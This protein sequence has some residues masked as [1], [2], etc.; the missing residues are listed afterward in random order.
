[1]PSAQFIAVV[2]GLRV[3]S[4]GTEIIKVGRRA[5]GVKLVIAGR[6]TGAGFGTAP[7]LVVADEI[8]LAAVRIGEVADSHDGSGDLG[9]QFGGGCGTGEIPAVSDVAGADEDRCLI[10]WRCGGGVTASR[11]GRK[12]D[13]RSHCH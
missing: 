7:G 9:E 2:A 13:E 11:P 6:G 12:C 5:C 1:M 8:L 4:S 3:A 10:P